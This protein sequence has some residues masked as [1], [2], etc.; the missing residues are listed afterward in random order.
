MLNP[1][2]KSLEK[3]SHKFWNID[4]QTAAFL[5]LIIQTH[6]YKSVLE[7]GTSNAY[8]ALHL[9][10]ALSKTKGHLYTIESHKDRQKLAEKNIKKSGLSKHVTLIKGHAPEDIPPFPKT[11]DIAFFDATKEEHPQYFKALKTRIKPKGLIITDN[12]ISHKKELK[13]YFQLL[14][15]APNWSSTLLNIGTGLFISQ[16][17][18]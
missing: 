15:K 12:A 13:T 14:N 10:E 17:S 6:N 5:S 9:G 2:L 3:T 16:K 4:P 8:S 11:L 7:I 18:H 1:L